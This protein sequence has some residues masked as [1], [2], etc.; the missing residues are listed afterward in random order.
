[1]YST[2]YTRVNIIAVRVKIQGVEPLR[3]IDILIYR[4]YSIWNYK[5][6]LS[7]SVFGEF[8]IWC[9]SSIEFTKYKKMKTIISSQIALK[10]WL[11]TLTF[12]KIKI[13]TINLFYFGIVIVY[14]VIIAMAVTNYA[15]ND[16]VAFRFG[17]NHN[18]W[19]GHMITFSHQGRMI[20]LHGID[21][22]ILNKI[23]KDNFLL[24]RNKTN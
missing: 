18:I 22:F 20:L 9:S 21:M 7:T 5:N 23:S 10:R 4:W 1:M 24:L 2:N 14:S 8:R 19:L 11:A 3:H 6:T 16:D 15:I 17:A 13:Y 12:F